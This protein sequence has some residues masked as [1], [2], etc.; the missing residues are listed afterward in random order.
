MVAC[1]IDP[2]K[3]EA[4]RHNARV[5]GVQDRIEFVVTDA[6]TFLRS[7]RPGSVDVV[8]LSPPWGGPAYLEAPEYD[9]KKML[10]INSEVNGENLFHLARR[11]TAN[12]SYFLPRTT[13]PESLSSLSPDQVCEVEDQVLNKKLKTRT[14]FYGSLCAAY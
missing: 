5:Y 6:I 11:L 13:P 1:D 14:A 8:F 7:L 2:Q 10:L 4:A 9:L 3:I 12:V